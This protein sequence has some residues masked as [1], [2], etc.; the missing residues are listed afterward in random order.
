[1][2]LLPFIPGVPVYVCAG[3]LI[4]RATMS[5]AERDDHS[6]G[7]APASFW[8][9]LLVACVLSCVLKFIAIA[10]QQEVF[11]RRLGAHISVRA[12]CQ[13][14]SAAIRAGRFVLAQPGCS[15]GKTMILCGG[16]DWPTSVLTGILRLP[17][18]QMLFGSI[19]VILVIVPSTAA[20]ACLSMS[21]RPGWGAA[22]NLMTLLAVGLQ[23]GVSIGF[24]AVVERAATVHAKDIAALPLDEEVAALD[25]QRA[26]RA[27]AWRVASDW[28]RPGYPR[29]AR[30][31]LGAAALVGVIAFHLTQLARPFLDVSVADK[32]TEAPLHGNALRVVRGVYGWAVIICFAL[33]SGIWYVHSRW[34]DGQIRVALLAAERA[35]GGT[36]TMSPIT[37][38]L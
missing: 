8:L 9:G 16:P 29:A 1:M 36:G 11:G 7:Y 30:V 3:V 21:D 13:V 14:N 15:F 10:I 31:A 5:V 17:L 32:Y 20:G 23:L 18:G 38:A 12:A 33:A 4:P 27:R 6:S 35:E 37:R 25:E 22:A 2:F 26:A 28:R 34:L 19:P 24:L